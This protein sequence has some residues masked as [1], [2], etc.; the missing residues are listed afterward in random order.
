MEY[1][2]VDTLGSTESINSDVSAVYICHSRIRI[3][4]IYLL[5][6]ICMSKFICCCADLEGISNS[7]VT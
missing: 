6:C 2:R 3:A 1:Q 5:V 7:G 4:Y